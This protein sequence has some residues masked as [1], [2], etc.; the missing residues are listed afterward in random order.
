MGQL[1]PCRLSMGGKQSAGINLAIEDVLPYLRRHQDIEHGPPGPATV[2]AARA[3][4]IH[5]A[6]EPPNGQV[7][8][9]LSETIYAARRR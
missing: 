9:D 5:H 3:N 1:G 6:K 7:L 8:D 2:Y 4:A